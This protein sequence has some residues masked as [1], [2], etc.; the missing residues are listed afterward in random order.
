MA[1]S[2][3]KALG[4]SS[5]VRYTLGVGALLG[6]STVYTEVKDS[7]AINA[8]AVTLVLD[9][10]K[11]KLVEEKAGGGGG[12][13]GLLK[14]LTD[15][16]G[17]EKSI[18]VAD[19]AAALR[20][21]GDDTRIAG[22]LV[23]IPNSGNVIPKAGYAP[24]QELRSSFVAFTTAKRAARTSGND[25]SESAASLPPVSTA[26]AASFAEFGNGTAAYYLATG[27][28]TI[29]MQP[30]GLLSIVGFGAQTTFVRE[31]LD[32][33]KIKATVV[34]RE[35]YKNALNSVTERD[36][37]RAHADALRSFLESVYTEVVAGIS[38]AREVRPWRVRQLI[39]NAPL[40]AQKCIK[41]GLIDGAM[42]RD[43]VLAM[44]QTGPS[45]GAADAV[46]APKANESA[47]ASKSPPMMSLQRYTR[48]RKSEKAREEFVRWARSGFAT[49]DDVGR[50]V[51]VT[52][53]G[54]IRAGTKSDDRWAKN[55]I[56]SRDAAE[57]LR[58]LREKDS[59]K[60]VVLKVNSPGGSA[61]G[62]DEVRR[63][64]EMLRTAGIP[65][66]VS[67]GSLAASGGYMISCCANTI[68]AQ[69][70]TLTGSIGVL[71]G[72][73]NIEDFLSQYGISSK[74]ISVGKNAMLTSSTE[75]VSRR[76]LRQLNAYI[77]EIYNEFI[78]V[79]AAGR[80]MSARQV[81]RVARGRIWS[82][83]AAQKIGL[84]DEL[85]GID[86]AIARAKELAV[87]ANPDGDSLESL[88]VVEH[89]V[90]PLAKLLAGDV[91]G[92]GGMTA[93]MMID[94]ISSRVLDALVARL[95]SH[96]IAET[97]VV[98]SEGANAQ[99]SHVS[100]FT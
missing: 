55:T 54:Q 95:R 65:V 16:F 60:A 17:G 38:T 67:M 93:D 36:Y 23:N 57:T 39:N 7:R 26:W 40:N 51:I 48:I 82:G 97:G 59:T 52:L 32:K 76:Q 12:G 6:A 90:S 41:A 68:V 70:T 87:K 21:A 58:S 34:A 8:G 77:D 30:S 11:A 64:V 15:G 42:Y 25:E 22:L 83:A 24:Y 78:G 44:Y 91:G 3:L 100:K 49:A 46:P 37:T 45:Q 35:E 61:L 99:M 5:V 28:D 19:A 2:F 74:S 27:C 72:K 92:A 96:L 13:G 62:S 89:R 85:G 84:V 98:S 71:F 14:A 50:V 94:A 80:Q 79:V 4:Q 43:E 29:L 63:E 56:W 73:F 47:K 53:A 66:V 9:L 33:L 20:L 1:N 10:E 75:P 81:R 86:V 88:K 69:P 31:L 18:V